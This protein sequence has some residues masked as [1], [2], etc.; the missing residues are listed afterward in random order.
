MVGPETED[1]EVGSQLPSG[2]GGGK[3]YSSF[4]L[5]PHFKI[6]T[7][8]SFNSLRAVEVRATPLRRKKKSFLC[9]K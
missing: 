4:S 2:V 9:N 5:R 3:E 1:Q 8:S 7:T 6:F